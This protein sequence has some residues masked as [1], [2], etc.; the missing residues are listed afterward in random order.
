LHPFLPGVTVRNGYPRIRPEPK[1]AT[2]VVFPSR[3]SKQED[4]MTRA[5]ISILTLAMAATP[6]V[7]EMDMSGMIRAD[8]LIG[9]DVYTT[10]E[11]HDEMSW[12]KTS[13]ASVG[14]DWNDVGEIEDIVLDASGKMVGIVV[15]VGGFLNIAD[16]D[17]F[18]GADEFRIT[19]V[20]GNDHAVVTRW[21][22][23]QLEAREEVK[24]GFWN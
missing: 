5:K 15:E 16:K 2:F 9:N 6:A 11:A 7:A 17:I 20:D 3:A 19:P 12:G 1:R 22:E 24:D 4:L 21:N 13:Y 8:D 10:N 18:L 14:V 23:E